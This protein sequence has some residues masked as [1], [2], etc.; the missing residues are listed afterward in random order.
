MGNFLR[1]FILNDHVGFLLFS[2]AEFVYL[3]IGCFFLQPKFSCKEWDPNLPTLCL[4]NPEYLAPE[5]ILSVSCETA[6]DMYSLGTVVYAVFNNGKP[7][8]EI[9]KQDIYKSF[10]RQLDQVSVV[11]NSLLICLLHSHCVLGLWLSGW[12]LLWKMQLLA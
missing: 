7:I 12:P 2:F 1:T 9:N 3:F 11:N 5:Y 6:S 10:S 8:F 4:P